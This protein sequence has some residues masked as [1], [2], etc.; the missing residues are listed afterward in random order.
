M[1][2]FLNSSKIA[3]P[4]QTVSYRLYTHVYECELELLAISNTKKILKK[5]EK[6]GLADDL[7][8]VIAKKLAEY[9]T[10]TN[11][12]KT[13]A[14][15]QH[16][17]LTLGWVYGRLGKI[18][19]LTDVYSVMDYITR[20]HFNK[21]YAHFIFDFVFGNKMDAQ[22]MDWS[23]LKNLV[24]GYAAIK[25]HPAVV[26][27][28]KVMSLAF[29]GGILES[30]GVEV[31]VAE[32]WQMVSDCFIKIQA[33]TD[34]IAAVIDLIHFLGERISAFCLTGDWKS[35]VHT[36]SSY[37]R[38]VD[39]C[40]DCL[41]KKV[42]L[43]NPGAIGLD[44]HT[45][46]KTLSD[47]ILEGE[48]IKR[49][50]R[51]ADE[52]DAVSQ[53][54][55]K[56][57][58]LYND[59]IITQACGKFRQ[60]PFSIMLAAGTG[61][62]K[63]SFVDTLITHY[64]KCYDKSLDD[65]SIYTRTASEDHWN[66]FKTSMWACVLD[67]VAFINPNKGTE[68][69]SLTDILQ[70]VNNIPF[71]PPQAAIEDKGRTPFTCELVVA[72]TNTKNLCAHNWFNNPQ[73]I[74]RRL[75]YVVNLIPKLEF[76]HPET[77]MI[78]TTKIPVTLEG[79]YPDLWDIVVE[80]VTVDLREKVVMKEILRT[81]NIYEFI[82][83]YNGWIEEHKSSQAAFMASK[84]ASKAV[85][86]CNLH[87]LPISVCPCPT[88]G[89]VPLEVQA[90]SKSSKFQK[91][92][93]SFTMT[94]GLIGA[95]IAYATYKTFEFGRNCANKV[96][97][98]D[99]LVEHDPQALYH[100]TGLQ[101]KSEINKFV[102]DKIDHLKLITRISV[103]NLLLRGL[104][105][106]YLSFKP[107]LYKLMT[108]VAVLSGLGLT[109]AFLRREFP[110][111]LNLDP[112][113]DID[114]VGV[115]PTK[116]NEPENVWRKDDYEP[117]EFIGRLATSWS[118]LGLSQVSS[119]VA[120]NVIWCRTTH[121]ETKHIKFR[122]LCVAG[123]LYV[124]P[125]HVLPANDYFMMQVI[126]ENNAEGCNGNIT[127]KVSQSMI[128]R[129]QNK[130]LAFF[131][132]NHMPPRRNLLDLLPKT[133]FK[134]DAPGRMI[135]RNPNGSLDYISTKRTVTELSAWVEQFNITTD[136]CIS[137][138]IRE[139]VSGEC[140]SPV[141]VQMPNACF[142][143]GTHVLGGQQLKAVCMP[144]TRDLVDEVIL[145]F[146]TPIVECEIP[147]LTPQFSTVISQ[148][149]TTRFFNEGTVQVFG[150]YNGFKPQPKSTA[151]D[152]PFTSYLLSKGHTRKYGPAPMKGYTPLHLGLKPMLQKTMTF[153]ED[154]LR[155]CSDSFINDVW[156]E[157]PQQFR[158]ELREPIPLKVALNGFPGTKFIDSMNF[159]TS[160]G[161]PHNKSKRNFIVRVPADDIW[162]H[163]VIV[164]DVIK[165]EISEC[166][167][168]M[169]QGISVSPVFM[170]H[171]KDEA[172]PLRKVV[173]GKAR[174][175][176]GGPFAWSTCVRMVLLPF[177]RVMQC[178]K[179]LF[180]C[181]PGTNAT[182]IEW[183]RLYDYLTQFGDQCLIAGDF[184]TFDKLM[185]ALVILEAFRMIREW[186]KLAGASIEIL[187]AIQVIAEG[188]AFA[189]VNFN[190]DLMQFFGS[191]PSGHPLTV[192][193]NC[194]V[195]SLYMR[196]CYHELNPKCE[197]VSF[198][199]FIALITY[200]DDNA[201]GS[202]V[203]W[204]NHT[205][206]ARV[207]ATVG[208]KYTMAEKTAE[209][210]PFISI[211]E[212]SFLKRT[213]R[214]EPALD[215]HMACLDTDSIWKSLMIFVPSKTDSP[216][217][218]SIDIVRSAVSEWFFYGRERFEKEVTFL[219]DMI[220][221]CDLTYYVEEGTFPSWDDLAQR[222]IDSS[223]S[224]LA[225]EPST[226]K[227][228]VGECVWKFRCD[229]NVHSQD[230]EKHKFLRD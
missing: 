193:I 146:A 221:S 205:A 76:R 69:P 41:D 122:A 32:M 73:A 116:T 128:H 55:S 203:S 78:D 123:H 121:S 95:G 160:A 105:D 66:N 124:V 215:A 7:I 138:V 188:V 23:V 202:G 157:L 159:N 216:Q 150:S 9:W 199:K 153:K 102:G 30:L 100:L 168:K 90:K 84:Q 192:I 51:G 14:L 196:Y 15:V 208:V 24:S 155:K 64:A 12:T 149:C 40:F 35:L 59:I 206:I 190:G 6:Q 152:T 129:V 36:P 143:A 228:L 62:A 117:S 39:K 225:F 218:Q 47:L 229:C 147:K 87:K 230:C 183:R 18:H 77:N 42:A 22:S 10:G 180:E 186:H 175:F 28:L 154:V 161:Y 52:K 83:A 212:V 27:F 140:G 56:I 223:N 210:V 71:S 94:Q 11:S 133:G 98:A 72:T 158:D 106:M 185:G 176:M 115:L 45:Y 179:Y 125:N 211:S 135:I 181:A 164:D 75:P 162:Q 174:I 118:S 103:K 191:N 112:Q 92:A 20:I 114:E 82:V 86:L 132:I 44:Y 58:T 99:P 93:E 31:K 120:R 219:K 4:P 80:K 194:L 195:N 207:L 220:T 227:K 97:E 74:Q 25:N 177:V 17:L 79:Y 200:G 139:T 21:P 127:F 182:S 187:N 8:S 142:I 107:Y 167:E 109:V 166:W 38:W 145:H 111:L 172:L 110:D 197:V 148:R 224:Y 144:I 33:N 119:I 137:D 48:E 34:F 54:L 151:C 126:H 68:D 201:I 217:K 130:E 65:G 198:K 184:E 85:K 91:Q 189:F 170:Q 108:G 96:I 16:W 214:W 46:V 61:V 204:F 169:T 113:V 57:R 171:L 60:S 50:L 1:D 222:F 88:I 5:L 163:P 3:T 37:T 89:D 67:D 104:H 165:E 70:V 173:A 2:K 29:S 131:E 26:K 19:D 141:V 136:I 156:R 213:F 178:N 13:Y 101:M 209:S 49:Y 226:T 43:A 134:C 81:S 63:S 53:V